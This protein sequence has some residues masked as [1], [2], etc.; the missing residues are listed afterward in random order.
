MKALVVLC[1]GFKNNSNTP[2]ADGCQ[3]RAMR[4]EVPKSDGFEGFGR[5]IQRRSE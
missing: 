5:R 3:G 2:L 4:K 1:K